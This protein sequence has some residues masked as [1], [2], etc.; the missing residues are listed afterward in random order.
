[1]KQLFIVLL[2]ISLSVNAQVLPTNF[3]HHVEYN[4]KHGFISMNDSLFVPFIYDSAFDFH[5]GMAGVMKDGKWGFIDE[6][7]N[8]VIE[9][10]YTSVQSFSEGL[11]AVNYGTLPAWYYIEKDG[12]FYRYNKKTT[13]N[14]DSLGSFHNGLAL[15]KEYG[16]YYFINKKWEKKISAYTIRS[17][18]SEGFAG[19]YYSGDPWPIGNGAGY[20]Y[21]DTMYDKIGRSNEVIATNYEIGYDFHEGLAVVGNLNS[22]TWGYI[23][24]TGKDIIPQRTALMAFDFSEGYGLIATDDSCL[25]I[26]RYGN[27][28]LTLP[29]CRFLTSVSEGIITYCKDG[30]YGYMKIDGGKIT[31]PFFDEARPFNNGYAPVRLGIK[32][33][34]VDKLG[35]VKWITQGFARI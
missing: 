11:S 1:M 18:F 32:W 14:S 19:Y 30:K 24:T 23:D 31:E 25:Y 16:Y 29:Y 26:D 5:E 22:G 3:L 7:G 35:N 13:T 27:V 8:V 12:R 10:K 20:R 28:K 4:G 9:I 34:L 21:I 33:G 15:V 6:G 2:A 17:D